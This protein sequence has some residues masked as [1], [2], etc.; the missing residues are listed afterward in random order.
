MHVRC[1]VTS[2][3]KKLRG[4]YKIILGVILEG[5]FATCHML[6]G[7]SEDIRYIQSREVPDQSRGASR[8][9]LR[10]PFIVFPKALFSNEFS[11][12]GSLRLVDVNS[13]TL[14]YVDLITSTLSLVWH[15]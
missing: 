13:G 1:H 11:S 4:N 5:D 6:E 8:C 12:V 2:F 15:P 14:E 3:A 7:N 9:Q 10:S